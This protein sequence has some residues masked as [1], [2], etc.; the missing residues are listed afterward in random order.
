MVSLIEVKI[1]EIET[2]TNRFM[3]VVALLLFILPFVA[4]VNEELI[5]NTATH[6]SVNTLIRIAHIYLTFR[7]LALYRRLTRAREDLAVL[8]SCVLHSRTR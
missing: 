1:K 2:A 3:F 8:L 5:F 6:E 7:V 4:K